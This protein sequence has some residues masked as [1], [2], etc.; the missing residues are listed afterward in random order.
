MGYYIEHGDWHSEVENLQIL[1][2]GSL[3]TTSLP[4]LTGEWVIV[5]YPHGD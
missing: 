1:A 5:I 4:G 3:Q 2:G